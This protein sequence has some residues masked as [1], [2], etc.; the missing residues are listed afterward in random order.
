MKTP[1]SEAYLSLLNDYLTGKGM[2]LDNY[3]LMRSDIE[4]MMA[5]YA[6]ILKPEIYVSVSE[7]IISVLLEN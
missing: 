1:N 6:R 4:P 2:D 5:F 7:Y 3:H